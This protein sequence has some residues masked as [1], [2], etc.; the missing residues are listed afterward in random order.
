MDA[1][2]LSVSNAYSEALKRPVTKGGDETGLAQ[3]ASGGN[4]ADMLKDLAEGVVE[5]TQKVETIGIQA[6]SKQ[7]EL[8]DVVTAV[9]NAE[10]ALESVV[11][12]RDRV[13]QAYQDIIKMPI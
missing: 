11:A 3:G 13:V 9:T 6:A 7:A 12:V 8:L 4:F 10:L 5:T 1:K 2:S